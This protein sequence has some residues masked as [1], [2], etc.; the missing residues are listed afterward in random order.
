MLESQAMVKL[1]LS[2]LL[3]C[4]LQSAAFSGDIDELRATLRS[5]V[6]KLE[7]KDLD[8]FLEY[9]HPSAILYTRTRI[10]PLDRE[11]VGERAWREAFQ[12]FFARVT[13]VAFTKADVNFRIIEDTGLVWGESRLAI[14]M[15]GGGGSDYDRRITVVCVRHQGQW[16]IA[17]WNE[18]PIPTG[19]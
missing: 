8:G 14:D 3:F 11:S 5:A 6:E 4:L 12:D 9:W 15:K 13:S 10:F 7:K 17:L 16:K 18:A 2:T 1:L 19:Q